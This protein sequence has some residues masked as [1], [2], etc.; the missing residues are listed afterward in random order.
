MSGGEAAAGPDPAPGG[1]G[2][3]RRRAAALGSVAIAL[4]AGAGGTFLLG[5]A[6]QG[7]IERGAEAMA[8]RV[9][10]GGVVTG[11]VAGCA[12][13]AFLCL[14][15]LLGAWFGRWVGDGV[16]EAWGGRPR[17]PC[18]WPRTPGRRFLA[19]CKAGFAGYAAGVAFGLLAMALADARIVG[20]TTTAA[21]FLAAPTLGIIV[22]RAVQRRSAAAGPAGSPGAAAAGDPPAAAAEGAG[23]PA[24]A[25]S[26]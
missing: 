13:L 20:E 3:L 1:G 19:V 16:H 17:R 12:Y 22:T 18:G 8:D 6:L 14:L 9:R 2:G 4:A 10:D 26:A 24:P 5:W 15:P 25:G 11:V 23:A 7:I 21:L